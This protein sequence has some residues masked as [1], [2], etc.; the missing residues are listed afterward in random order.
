MLTL[1]GKAKALRTVLTVVLALAIFFLLG[2]GLWKNWQDIPFEQIRFN[3]LFIL[4]SIASM[5]GFFT[6]Y[7]VAWR[8]VLSSYGFRLRFS[9]CFR[10][11]AISNLGKY[12][13][14]KVWFALGRMYLARR[15]DVPEKVTMVSAVLETS[16]LAVSAGM[17]ALATIAAPWEGNLSP[18]TS[19]VVLAVIVFGLIVVHPAVF[20]KGVNTVLK[21]LKRSEIQMR[22]SYGGIVGLLLLYCFSWFWQGIGFFLMVKSFYNVD[23]SLFPVL[24]GVFTLAWITGF[25]NLLTPAGIGVR[26]GVITFFLSFYVPTP[27][28]I[29]VA[30]VTRGWSTVV[31]LSFAGAS[32]PGIKKLCRSE[33]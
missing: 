9:D 13:P 17:I 22:L 1:K 15:L 18:R 31:D 10:V 19:L 3:Y 33:T 26:E 30:L 20:T 24:L 14:G 27:I 21:R 8:S 11:L 25:L 29:I 5:F 12:I 28:A 23:L 7:V 16:L 6:V 2:R 4:L 32:L